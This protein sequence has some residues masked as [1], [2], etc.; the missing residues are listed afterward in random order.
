MNYENRR[1]DTVAI[2]KAV[3]FVRNNPNKFPTYNIPLPK[4]DDP[5]HIG[6]V[7]KVINGN[8]YVI[9]DFCDE[10]AICVCLCR[11]ESPAVC[12]FPIP[13]SK[14]TPCN[15]DDPEEECQE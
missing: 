3:D 5:I 8:R 10:M 1:L 4:W 2:Q 13:V 14:L 12:A 15:F 9:V 7:V 6:A 11:T